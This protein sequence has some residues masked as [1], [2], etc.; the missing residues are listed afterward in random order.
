V[1]ITPQIPLTGSNKVRKMPLR[2]ERWTTTDPI[3]WRADGRTSAW[4][5]MTETDKTSLDARFAA[6]G[7]EAALR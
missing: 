1:R 3:W 2:Q 7:R 6:R 5:P 4:S